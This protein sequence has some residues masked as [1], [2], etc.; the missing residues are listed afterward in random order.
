MVSVEDFAARRGDFPTLRGDNV[1]TYFDNACMTLKPD[2]VIEAI[3]TYYNEHPSCGGRS[4][5]RYAMAVTRKMMDA[6]KK[7]AS[8]INAPHHD[9]VVFTKNATHSLNQIA[10]GQ[11]WSEGDVLLTSER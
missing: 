2:S 4:V 1:P 3:Q 5:H 6:R 11:S 10:K 7:M 8:F 9:E